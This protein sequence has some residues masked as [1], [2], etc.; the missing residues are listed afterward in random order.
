M[1]IG[2]LVAELVLTR[3]HVPRDSTAE[4]PSKVDVMLP[5][6]SL[7]KAKGDNV[8]ACVSILVD[9]FCSFLCNQRTSAVRKHESNQLALTAVSAD[10]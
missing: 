8:R 5:S 4:P 9:C 6:T 2:R 7:Q 1:G 10:A 3:P